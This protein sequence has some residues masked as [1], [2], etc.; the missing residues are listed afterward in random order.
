[1]TNYYVQSLYTE[2]QIYS[3]FLWNFVLSCKSERSFKE[4]INT[5]YGIYETENGDD[6][7]MEVLD[8]NTEYEPAADD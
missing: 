6:I 2:T 4:D 3:M 5:D 7:V 1:M 8:R